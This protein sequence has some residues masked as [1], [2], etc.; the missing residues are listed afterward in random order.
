MLIDREIAAIATLAVYAVIAFVSIAWQVKHKAGRLGLWFIYTVEKVYAPLFF[1]WRANRRCP[2]PDDGPAIILANHRSP[3][4]PVFVWAQ[5]HLSGPS[6]RMRPI[7]FMTAKEYFDVPGVGWICRTL[8]S[9][10]VNRDGA[11]MGPVREALRRLHN[12]E[13]VGVFPEGRINKGEGLLPGNPGI[14]WLALTAK[15]PVF[16]VF[17]HGA[18]QG[19]TMIEPFYARTR[20]QVS[21]GDSIDLSAYYGQRKTREL[22][23]EVTELMMTRLGQV[24]GLDE[25]TGENIEPP[26]LPITRAT[27]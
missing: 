25:F 8:N 21:Y 11:D 27:G 17:V 16:P 1:H 22:L 26:T 3:V 9:I 13:L 12:G 24:G 20:V 10:P 4:D 15:V 7:S 19:R 6:G 14:A 23:Q 18:P 5:H 2:F